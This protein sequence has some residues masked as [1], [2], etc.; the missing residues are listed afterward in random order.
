M[1]RG[2]VRAT[3]RQRLGGLGPLPAANFLLPKLIG[4]PLDRDTLGEQSRVVARSDKLS[5]GLIDGSQFQKHDARS[6]VRLSRSEFN[7]NNCRISAACRNLLLLADAQRAPALLGLI[8]PMLDRGGK[9]TLLLRATSA[10]AESLFPLLPIPVEVQLAASA[11][12]P[13][14]V[15]ESKKNGLVAF[16]LRKR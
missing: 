15:A 12:D 11:G 8:D 16:T 3:I 6:L 2:V 10:E 13:C 5:L 4:L 14:I 7:G 1:T 9:V